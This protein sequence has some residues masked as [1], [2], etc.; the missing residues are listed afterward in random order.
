MFSV[1]YVWFN[2]E[3]TWLSESTK[4]E[5]IIKKRE[6]KIHFNAICLLRSPNCR[7]LKASEAKRKSKNKS[8]ET[9]KHF[10]SH[11]LIIHACNKYYIRKTKA[12][13]FISRFGELFL[14]FFIFALSLS[15]RWVY[16]IQ[17]LL[18]CSFF[19]SRRTF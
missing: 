3:R 13:N 9:R 18:L 16:L 14:F 8:D 4:I 10:A 17:W 6:K 1:S 19:N 5:K 7:I 15:H 11:L 12:A 2:D